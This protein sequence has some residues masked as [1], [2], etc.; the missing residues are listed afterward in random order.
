MISTFE[1]VQEAR[2]TCPS[3][4][5]AMPTSNLSARPRDTK[6]GPNGTRQRRCSCPFRPVAVDSSVPEK[7]F[8]LLSCHKIAGLGAASSLSPA[9]IVSFCAT[10]P[11]ASTISSSS[12]YD[13]NVCLALLYTWSSSP[14]KWRAQAQTQAH[15][16]IRDH[17]FQLMNA[18]SCAEIAR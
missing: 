9:Y 10:K 8:A 12:L 11:S 13:C 16:R 2:A 6:P 15:V 7:R 1:Q 4:P 3:T 14:R 18:L 5:R 17:H